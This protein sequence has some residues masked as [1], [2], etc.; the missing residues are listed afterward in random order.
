MKKSKL[1]RTRPIFYIIIVLFL[2]ITIF[3]FVWT[4]L[5]SIKPTREI[6]G[7]E[8]YRAFTENPTWEHYQITIEKGILDAVL[9]S[10]I[11]SAITTLYVTVVSSLMAYAISR[12]KFKGK[13]LVMSL[14]LAISMFPSMI[15]IGPVYNM[16]VKLGWTNSYWVVLPYCT[17]TIPITVWTLIAHFKKI[18]ITVEEAARIDGASRFRILR[19]IVYPLAAPGIFSAAIICF[20]TVWNE[21]LITATI[22]MSDAVRTVPV[23]IAGYRTQYQIMW[24]QVTAASVIVAIPTMLMVLLF[25]RRIIAGLTSGAV[26]E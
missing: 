5:T 8:A 25:Q 15:I 23:A 13:N 2:C 4:F 26:K 1:E 18:P 9:N 3:P 16:F 19:T 6:F 12:F 21:Y 14:V 17:I 7:D 11:I 10:L 24:G 22:N 20:I